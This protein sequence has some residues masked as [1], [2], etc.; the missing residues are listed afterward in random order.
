MAGA[1]EVAD[2][3]MRQAFD[4][5]DAV[6]KD[7][8]VLYRGMGMSEDWLNE[9]AS[10]AKSGKRYEL[11]EESFNSNTADIGLARE[12]ALSSSKR[13]GTIPVI[14]KTY[15]MPGVRG[16]DIQAV[17]YYDEAEILIDRGYTRVV[18]AMKRNEDGTVELHSVIKPSSRK[19]GDGKGRVIRSKSEPDEEGWVEYTVEYPDDAHMNKVSGIAVSCRVA[20]YTIDELAAELRAAGFIE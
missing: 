10:Y 9:I 7:G 4:H 18:V 15:V 13:N 8:A 2:K 20:T 11:R 1:T 16:I 14:H 3:L 17:N 6:L 5:A 19:L 12:F